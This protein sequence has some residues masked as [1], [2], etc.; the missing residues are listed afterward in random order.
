M[1]TLIAI[2]PMLKAAWVVLFFLLFLGVVAWVMRPSA[3][4]RYAAM[5]RLP[6][7]DDPRPPRR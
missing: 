2:Y 3:R 6:L 7:N 4:D 1:D 5:A